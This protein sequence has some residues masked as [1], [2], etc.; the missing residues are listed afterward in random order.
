MKRYTDLFSPKFRM[1]VLIFVVVLLLAIAVSP[2]VPL[3][4]TSRE[5]EHKSAPKSPSQSVV[6]RGSTLKLSVQP[7]PTPTP[8]PTISGVF[9]TLPPGAQL[10]SEAECAV[11]VHRSS[12]E[13]RPDNY[14]AN[15][16]VPTAQQI[17]GLAPWGPDNGQVVKA[18]TASRLITGNFTGT[19][20]EILQWAACKWGIDVNIARAQAVAESHWQQ[21]DRGDQ[22]NDA[23]LC[24]PGTWN[25]TSCYQSYG[26]LQIKYIY[27]KAAWPMSRDDT[28]FNAEYSYGSIRGCYEGWATYLYERTPVAGYPRYHRG[29]IWGCVGK[30][31]SGSW[32]DQGA[33]DY[34]KSVK[35]YMANK[36]W[37]QPGF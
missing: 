2:A 15:H 32:Y 9:T 18:D 13:P 8:I 16:R 7:P 12:W 31:Y 34:I 23:S 25:G 17:A 29:D 26:I 35:M 3:A 27:S 22:T 33:L 28:A 5:L 20:D 11:R 36:Q 4:Q 6:H 1:T 19:T 30:W 24:P 10:P 14:A 21:S 37:L